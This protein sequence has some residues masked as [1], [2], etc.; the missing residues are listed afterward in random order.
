MRPAIAPVRIEEMEQDPDQPGERGV[1][2]D[3]AADAD[4]PVERLREHLAARSELVDE[5]E[6][7][8]GVPL[9]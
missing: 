9:S 8:Q 1:S 3:A 6:L 2:D 5:A 4:E 7:L